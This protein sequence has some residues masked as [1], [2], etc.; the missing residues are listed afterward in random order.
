MT[1]VSFIS[2]L[3]IT[4]GS[5]KERIPKMFVSILITLLSF[6]GIYDIIVLL[7][8]A[9]LVSRLSKHFGDS[10]EFKKHK[11]WNKKLIILFV[12]MFLTW[13]TEIF[14]WNREFFNLLQ[15][16]IISDLIKL[17]TAFNIFVIFVLM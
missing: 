11:S 2:G 13:I 10:A 16:W 7:I 1:V 6:T 3:T 17:F 14:S 12:I 8:S 4:A 5:L 9:V 15:H